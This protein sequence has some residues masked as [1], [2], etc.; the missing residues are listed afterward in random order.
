MYEKSLTL[1]PESASGR[2]ALAKIR[3]TI[4]SQ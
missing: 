2:E 3:G 4:A 1:N